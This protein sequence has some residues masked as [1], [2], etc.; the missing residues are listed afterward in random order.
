MKFVF[1]NQISE[2]PYIN[3]CP[4]EVESLGCFQRPRFQFRKFITQQKPGQTLEEF[5]CECG[6]QVA[7]RGWSVFTLSD[8]ISA[9]IAGQCYSS[10]SRKGYDVLGTSNNC[11]NDAGEQCTESDTYCQ[12]KADSMGVYFILKPGRS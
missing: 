5:F 9:L 1:F 12:G 7:K 10:S 8:G 6:S 3:E 11:V 2:S 4:E